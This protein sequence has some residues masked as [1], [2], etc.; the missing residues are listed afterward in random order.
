MELETGEAFS[1]HCTV[2]IGIAG[3]TAG[4]TDPAA[5]IHEADRALYMA[6][7]TGRNRATAA[8]DLEP[9]APG[10]AIGPKHKTAG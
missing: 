6:K 10:A 8:W 5:L 1:I 7:G 4:M 2:S 3:Y 9:A